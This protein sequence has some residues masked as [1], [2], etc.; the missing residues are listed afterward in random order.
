MFPASPKHSLFERSN[1]HLHT[2]FILKEYSKYGE[3]NQGLTELLNSNENFSQQNSTQKTFVDIYKE[4]LYAPIRNREGYSNFLSERLDLRFDKYWNSF[5]STALGVA[6]IG[7][8]YYF[9]VPSSKLADPK[10]NPENLK[11]NHIR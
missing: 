2:L 3:E 11:T 8:I 1:R 5:L 10:S 7:A 9:M 4:N 6:S